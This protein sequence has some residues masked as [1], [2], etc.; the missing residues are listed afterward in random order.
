MNYLDSQGNPS[1]FG[2]NGPNLMRMFDRINLKNPELNLRFM[3]LYLDQEIKY[4][5]SNFLALYTF[6]SDLVS[7]QRNSKK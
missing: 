6:N 7:N 2:V 4:F 3:L 1:I 5:S